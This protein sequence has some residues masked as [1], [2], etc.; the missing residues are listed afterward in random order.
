MVKWTER[1]DAFWS[2]LSV[3]GL[4][5]ADLRTVHKPAYL[6]RITENIHD[7][8]IIYGLSLIHILLKIYHL[9]LFYFVL[10]VLVPFH[11]FEDTYIAVSYTHLDVYKRQVWQTFTADI[12]V[13]A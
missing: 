12:P 10:N 11:L 2:V 9:D 7:I 1:P 6:P 13:T 5:A 3:R 4:S 8:F